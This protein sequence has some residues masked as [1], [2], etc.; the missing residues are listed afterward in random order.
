M[1][2]FKYLNCKFLYVCVCKQIKMEEIYFKVKI[3][4]FE[5]NI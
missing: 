1:Q 2:L 3:L 4:F 5:S